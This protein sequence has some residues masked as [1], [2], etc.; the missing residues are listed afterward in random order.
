MSPIEFNKV[1]TRLPSDLARRVQTPYSA[2]L[3]LSIASA[4]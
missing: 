4:A 1:F 3:T 2:T